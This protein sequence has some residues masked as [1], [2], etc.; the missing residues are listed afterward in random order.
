MI[1]DFQTLMLPILNVVAAG[2]IAFRDLSSIIADKFSLS[3]D[4]KSQKLPSG[5]D[6]VLDNRIGWAIFYMKN[7]GLLE[8]PQRGLY[9]ITAKGQQLLTKKPSVNDI[10]AV[11]APSRKA[12]AKKRSEDKN[13][14][15]AAINDAPQ[16]NHLTP[17][18]RIY[19]SYDSIKTALADAIAM[20]NAMDLALFEGCGHQ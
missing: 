15:L 3:E 1:P 8:A 20:L 6:R 4:E 10:K 17:Y 11:I 19:Q 16:E 18:E 9:T 2:D 13:A 14:T 7:A 5:K 12:L